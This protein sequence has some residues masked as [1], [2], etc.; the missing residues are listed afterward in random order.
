MNV[1]DEGAEE[2]DA[3]SVRTVNTDD[4]RES[5]EDDDDDDLDA[6]RSVELTPVNVNDDLV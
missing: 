4:S 6:G 1:V 2:N 5:E 3:V